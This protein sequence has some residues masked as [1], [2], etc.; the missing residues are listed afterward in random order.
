MRW[1]VNNE[2]FLLILIL[3]QKIRGSSYMTIVRCWITSFGPWR[4][5]YHVGLY[6]DVVGRPSLGAARG[7]AAPGPRFQ[8][9]HQSIGISLLC[10][11]IH[12]Y[13]CTYRFR[14]SAGLEL[15]SFFLLCR[16]MHRRSPENSRWCARRRCRWP[17]ATGDGSHGTAH[18]RR[19]RNGRAK[20]KPEVQNPARMHAR[21]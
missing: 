3:A 18:A 2:S 12:E 11:H 14:R 10:S 8:E 20:G 5:L 16:L 1:K 15:Q 17:P 13:V 4:S 9:A 21:R 6:A 19:G 7:V